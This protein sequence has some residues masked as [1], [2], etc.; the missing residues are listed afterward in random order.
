MKSLITTLAFIIVSALLSSF[1][2][3][4][5]NT[6][7]CDAL[8]GRG[9]NKLEIGP[10]FSIKRGNLTFKEDGKNR[11]LINANGEL[12]L[13]GDRVALS[14]R[15]QE[16]VSAYYAQAEMAMDEFAGLAA[17][18]ASLGVS[19]A[20]K[21]IFR[22]LTGSLDEKKFEQEVEAEARKIEARADLACTYLQ[23][24]ERIELEMI[25]EVPGFRPMMF[26]DKHSI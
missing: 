9:N 16:L 22:L 10:N 6:P 5:H 18:A 4:A 21:A 3:Q 8:D 12:Y 26:R 23:E 1:P 24:I 17:D 25:T 7:N 14:P 20:S 2:V 19:A 11:M 15:G 13:D